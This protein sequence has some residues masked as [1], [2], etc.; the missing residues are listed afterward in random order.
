MKKMIIYKKGHNVVFVT[1]EEGNKL[2]F[3]IVEYDT[4]L[5]GITPN[6]IFKYLEKEGLKAFY[7]E[8]DF[9]HYRLNKGEEVVADIAVPTDYTSEHYFN[10]LL[11][12]L[13]T[14]AAL[15]NEK[16]QNIMNELNKTK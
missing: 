2:E 6:V 8:R 16:V 3:N 1:D 4:D 13:E 14:I 5:Y 12:T 7:S 9:V 11:K 15:K 10:R